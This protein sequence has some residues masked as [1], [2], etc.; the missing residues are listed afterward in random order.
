[1][2]GSVKQ[3]LIDGSVQ[4]D[5]RDNDDTYTN[6]ECLLQDA[7]PPVLTTISS[8][9]SSH[10][11][12]A[13][14]GGT[15]S[16]SFLRTV[17]RYYYHKGFF[18]ILLEELFKLLSFV[19]VVFLLTF[20]IN[21]VDYE[22]LI[23]ASGTSFPILYVDFVKLPTITVV[24]LSLCAVIFFIQLVLSVKR[25]ITYWL[26]RSFYINSL[27]FK[28]DLE[29]ARWWEVVC[30]ISRK[31]PKEGSELE[32]IQKVLRDENFLIGLFNKRIVDEALTIRLPWLYHSPLITE[33]VM[34]IFNKIVVPE[35]RGVPIYHNRDQCST[36]L[37]NH[38]RGLG[39]LSIF[40]IPFVLVFL[41]VYFFF[42]YGEQIHSTPTLLSTRRWTLLAK[43]KLREFN[44]VDHILEQR[45]DSCVLK[46][47]LYLDQ[48]QTSRSLVIICRFLSFVIGSLVVV[49]IVL[50]LINSDFVFELWGLSSVLYITI[51]TVLLGVT[52]SMVKPLYVFCD[53][54]GKMADLVSS[55]HYFPKRWQE[56]PN[57]A[58]VLKEFENFYSLRIFEW[59]NEVIS[60]FLVPYFLLISLPERAD[61]IVEYFDD[62]SVSGEFRCTFGT[63]SNPIHASKNWG[64]VSQSGSKKSNGGK[65][66]KSV[67]NFKVNYPCFLGLDEASDLVESLLTSNGGSLH[68]QFASF[69]PATVPSSPI[70][71]PTPTSTAT[72]TATTTTS[73]TSLSSSHIT[74]SQSIS[75]SLLG[76]GFS[77]PPPLFLASSQN[78]EASL[79]ALNQ[80]LYQK[81]AAQQHEDDDITMKFN[82]RS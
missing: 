7:A 68:S 19:F 29:S 67:I 25:V 12:V 23:H 3:P 70:N 60:V 54:D 64:T 61:K 52:R 40:M 66:E 55:T 17:Y 11:D 15:L 21:F 31:F 9:T 46:A 72:A 81:H 27:E 18:C 16:D 4:L 57:K 62:Y 49:F 34:F 50:A 37:K 56:N 73:A 71:S 78:P 48:F 53:P 26:I 43:W 47:N 80:V 51:L 41:L 38:L 6:A 30:Q 35:M 2:D 5:V 44:E 22:E 20:L 65:M 39:V 79:A 63:L 32:V 82:A 58:D 75:S 36:K 76:C 1:M 14:T 69:T 45:L 77:V 42:K 59:A 8:A 33:T 13:D 28:K 24:S 74:A 10:V